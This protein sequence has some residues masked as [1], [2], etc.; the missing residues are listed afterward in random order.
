MQFR[1]ATAADTEGIIT[2]LDG[3]FREYGDRVCL[4]G[5]EA[6][7]QDFSAHYGEGEFMVLDDGGRIVGTV[8]LKPCEERENV[9]WLKR[10]YLAPE[11]R[12]AGHGAK[13]VEWARTRTRELGRTRIECWSDVRFERAHA[14]YRKLGFDGPIERRRMTDAFEPYEEY[15]FALDLE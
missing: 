8:A 9:C 6:D 10:M 11:L 12:G 13:L 14:F 2:L 1:P 7:L 15:R 5:S 4:E 3:V